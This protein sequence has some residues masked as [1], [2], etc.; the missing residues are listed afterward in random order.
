MW[1]VCQRSLPRGI[2]ICRRLSIFVLYSGTRVVYWE[3]QDT[4][5]FQ[6]AVLET[7]IYRGKHLLSNPFT[8]MVKKFLLSTLPFWLS[9]LCT[10]GEVTANY[11]PVGRPKKNSSCTLASIGFRLMSVI[12]F[13]IWASPGVSDSTR[14]HQIRCKQTEMRLANVKRKTQIGQQTRTARSRSSDNAVRSLVSA[15]GIGGTPPSVGRYPAACKFNPKYVHVTVGSLL[16]GLKTGCQIVHKDTLSCAIR[17]NQADSKICLD[18]FRLPLQ[19]ER[20]KP[21]HHVSV[22]SS[23]TVEMLIIVEENMDI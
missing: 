21:E 3:I 19:S 6:Q 23:P 20:L 14:R 18:K 8:S 4:T 5:W 7:K 15:V 10:E 16:L 17:C 13:M 11:Q 22:Q 9:S 12:K 1:S 2:W